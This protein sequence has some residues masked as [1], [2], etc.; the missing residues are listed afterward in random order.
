MLGGGGGEVGF[1]G[2]GWGFWGWVAGGMG[3]QAACDN[4][5]GVGGGETSTR[6]RVL[7]LSPILKRK[8]CG[9]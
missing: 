8:V 1:W 4:L 9:L 7:T 3:D 5:R 2:V 6:S